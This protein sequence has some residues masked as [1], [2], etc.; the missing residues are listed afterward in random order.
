ME[1]QLKKFQGIATLLGREFEVSFDGEALSLK[2]PKKPLTGEDAA[3]IVAQLQGAAPAPAAKTP[4]APAKAPAPAAAPAKPAAAPAQAAKPA[5][6]PA[7]APAKPAAAPAAAAPAKPTNGAT[8]PATVATK[9]AVTTAPAKPAAV[10]A[11]AKAPAPAAAKPAVARPAQ[12]K[13][14]PPPPTEVVEET[15]GEEEPEVEA[16]GEVEDPGVEETGGAIEVADLN[17]D[18]LAELVPLGIRDVVGRL[19]DWGFQ[20]RDTLIT[21]CE[22]YK[23]DIG[24]VKAL[25]DLPE[26][27][28]RCLTV[29]QLSE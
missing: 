2:D 17:E 16:A 5:A 8:K 19:W 1:M 6:A 12:A 28:D 27:I 29:I 15:V 20:D 14:A 3:N 4:A 21:L 24:S 22:R 11:P 7:A 10:P 13:P 26:R 25:K 23:E 18:Q 9:P